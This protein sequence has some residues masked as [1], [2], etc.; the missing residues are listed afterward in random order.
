MLAVKIILALMSAIVI[1]LAIDH[2]IV[3]KD[4]NH[5]FDLIAKSFMAQGKLNDTTRDLLIDIIHKI[6]EKGEKDNERK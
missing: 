1:Y 5:K 3:M 6:R 4:I 2:Y